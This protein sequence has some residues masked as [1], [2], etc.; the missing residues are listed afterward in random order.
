MKP[1]FASSE[2]WLRRLTAL[3][4]LLVC[5]LVYS[6]TLS[7]TFYGYEGANA[8][9]ARQIMYLGYSD[10][11]TPAGI[12]DI[13]FYMPFELLSNIIAGDYEGTLRNFVIIHALPFA[14]SL[15]CL[16]FFFMAL[17]LYGSARLAASLTLLL[18]FTTMHLPYSKMGMELHHSLWILF[19]V[20]MIIRW[21][22]RREKKYLAL[23]GIGTGLILLTKLY[24]FV[25]SGAIILFLIYDTLSERERR[26]E[27]LAA[28]LHF[29]LPFCAM[30]I[31]LFIHNRL[32]YSGW[33][34]GQRYNVEYESKTVP[35]WQPLF[36]FLFSSGKS[37]FIYNPMLIA[38][39]FYLRPFFREHRRLAML[40]ILIFAFGFL[41]H[42]LMWIWTDE[43]WG[44]RKLHYLVPLAM[45]PLGIMIREFRRLNIAAR[46]A[47]IF[48]AIMGLFVQLLGTA[49]TYEAHPECLKWRHLSSMENIRH[50]PRLSHTTFNYS[51]LLSNIERFLTGN[52]HYFI[53]DPT[54]FITVRPKDPR[55]HD[56]MDLQGFSYFDFWFVDNNPLRRGKLFLFDPL[57]KY[58][59]FL[60]ISIPLAF[61]ALYLLSRRV[62]GEKKS[63]MR[64]P[65]GWLF[66]LLFAAG[67]WLCLVY[68]KA[69]TREK[70]AFLA[71]IP[72]VL[73]LAIGDDTR[74][75]KLLGNG[76]RISEWM[77]DPK[78]ASFKIPF[79]WTN[80]D[81]AQIFLPCKPNTSYKL[82]IEMVSIYPGR[83]SVWVNNRRLK[84]VWSQKHDF[85]LWEMI[86]PAEVV[87]N[88]YVST[89][90]IQHFRLHIPA[91]EEPGVS[92]DTSILGIMV[93]GL[94]WKEL[95]PD[96]AQK[97]R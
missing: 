59:L 79:R 83:Q 35:I 45:L 31:L 40:W 25:T 95:E 16:I 5:F 85:H 58:L 23:T 64:A 88:N 17:D 63:W 74:D 71:E 67:I 27:W 72:P 2:I 4:I 21:V 82:T 66:P 29:F 81:V 65:A 94:N 75:E 41:F 37:V 80:R 56:A 44:A 46:T 20:W 89:V 43:S 8:N 7:K 34:I 13:L 38:A 49:L 47:I 1:I 18:A 48:L 96:A 78:D 68:N 62:D 73:D 57:K 90:S 87:G 91:K 42:S 55:P 11:H 53:Y 15:I 3:S 12:L 19:S 86:V 30:V 92:K 24:G 54:Y 9:Y 70:N 36:G 76:W 10:Y 60:L 22:M 51:L 93:Y 14:A 28:F 50:N 77:N 39:V 32:R 33:L 52:T 97:K 69:Y 84:Y 61:F 26:K 6:L